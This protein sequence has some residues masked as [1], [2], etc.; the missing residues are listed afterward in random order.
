[1]QILRRLE[2][3]EIVSSGSDSNGEWVRFADGL[4]ICWKYETVTDQAI[5]NA[6]GDFFQDTREYTFPKPFSETPAPLATIFKWG[7]G[8]SWGTLHSVNTTTITVRG[9]DIQS[10]A[11]GTTCY[12]GYAAIGRWK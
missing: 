10:R 2:A 7:T 8:A 3:T 5:D 4:Q 1:M 11:T 6:Y 9:I 12:I